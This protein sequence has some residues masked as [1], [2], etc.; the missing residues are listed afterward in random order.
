MCGQSADPQVSQVS[1]HS[2]VQGAGPQGPGL[3]R[4]GIELQRLKRSM[5]IVAFL[6]VGMVIIA[7]ARIGII[8]IAVP[9]PVTRVIRSVGRSAPREFVFPRYSEH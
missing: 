5:V 6:D 1:T 9:T 7:S 2:P 4:P 8:G 3:S